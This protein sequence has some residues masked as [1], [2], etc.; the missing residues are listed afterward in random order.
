MEVQ[1]DSKENID[2][3]RDLWQ[4]AFH[5]PE[6]FA[7]YYFEQVFPKNQVLVAKEKDGIR[8]MLHLN[9]Y[10]WN[11]QQIIFHYIVGV[12]T[13]ENCRRQGYMARCLTKALQDMEGN[14]EPFTYLMPANPEYYKPFQFVEWKKEQRWEWKAWRE[15]RTKWQYS[16]YPARSKA[17]MERLQE[18]VACEK[19]G[20]IKGKNDIYAAYVLDTSENQQKILIQQIF[21]GDNAKEVELEAQEA[22]LQQV[23]KE[24]NER[25]GDIPIEIME[26]QPM[27]LRVLNLERFVPLLPYQGREQQLT[28]RVKDEIC[29]SNEGLVQI[30]LSEKGCSANK[31]KDI[32]NWLKAGKDAEVEQI[33][34][35]VSDSQVRSWSIEVLTEYL[36]KETK[37]ADKVYL[38]EIV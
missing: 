34:D 9:P 22:F 13:R 16:I 28:V 3:I 5:D 21:F 1:Y 10:V 6:A 17:Y 7:D 15:K 18:E 36:L 31:E 32:E 14:G 33:A 37:L 11:C 25:Y 23:E 30:T 27:M 38:M 12:A 4:E 2:A 35:C 8:S 20:I 24:L 26:S 29:K 19:G